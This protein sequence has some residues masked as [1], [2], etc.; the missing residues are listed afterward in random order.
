MN[1]LVCPL[2][3]HTLLKHSPTTQF[4]L[5]LG[6]LNRA[7][8]ATAKTTTNRGLG[9]TNQLEFHWLGAVASI[10]LPPGRNE[11][12][13]TRKAYAVLEAAAVLAAA[14][15]ADVAPGT[16]IGLPWERRA[17]INWPRLAGSKPRGMTAAAED[18]GEVPDFQRPIHSDNARTTYRLKLEPAC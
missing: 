3:T 11:S 5:S 17:T 18:R 2:R 10:H 8:K 4:I 16:F 15:M 6:F 12:Q 9:G 14:T 7:V 1:Q 13:V